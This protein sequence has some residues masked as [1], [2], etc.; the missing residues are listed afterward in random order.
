MLSFIGTVIVGLI[1]GLIARALKP[2]DDRMGLIMTIILGIA[3]SLVAGYVGR[4]LG[5][6][7]P[8]QPAGWIASVIGAIVLLV[9]YGV[10][11]RRT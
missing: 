2:G 4:A 1:V 5:W 8:G 3:G 10:V 11:R 9:I 7:Q 6:Y